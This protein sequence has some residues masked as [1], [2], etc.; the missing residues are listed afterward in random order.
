MQAVP[1]DTAQELAERLPEVFSVAAKQ[2]PH[3]GW[4]QSKNIR[5]Y[6]HYL[7]RVRV[8]SV[9]WFKALDQRRACCTGVQACITCT[10]LPASFVA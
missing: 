7:E 10:A 6:E 8:H 1:K 3:H 2:H 5:H 4:L 9:A